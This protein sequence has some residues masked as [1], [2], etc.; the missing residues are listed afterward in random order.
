VC[1]RRRSPPCR[2]SGWMMATF[3]IVRTC[4]KR[5]QQRWPHVGDTNGLQP[6]DAAH[7]CETD[8]SIGADRFGQLGNLPSCVKAT[9]S[10]LNCVLRAHNSATASGALTTIS[11]ERAAKP[12]PR[13][14]V[15]AGC[16]RPRA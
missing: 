1:T 15:G 11:R 12:T 3:G 2:D 14:T 16:A 10:R 4:L 8:R 9:A 5:T 13:T 7:H 6:A